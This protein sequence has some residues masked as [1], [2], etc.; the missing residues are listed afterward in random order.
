MFTRRRLLGAAGLVGIATGVSAC[1]GTSGPAEMRGA[2]SPVSLEVDQV[3]ETQRAAMVSASIA[4]GILTSHP[5]ALTRNA[6]ISPSSLTVS[7]AM[8]GEGASGASRDSLHETFDMIPD[9]RS[10]AIGALRQ[11]LVTYTDLPSGMDPD[12]PPKTPRVHQ[13]NRVVVLDDADV[14]QNFL[15]RLAT[16]YDTGVAQ[17]SRSKAEKNLDGWLKDQTAGL[18]ETSQMKISDDTRVLTQDTIV[19]AARWQNEFE[20]DDVELPFTT[21]DGTRRTVKAMQGTFTVETLIGASETEGDLFRT[22]RLPYDDGLAMDITLPTAAIDVDDLLFALETPPGGGWEDDQKQQV[23]ITMPIVDVSSA[24]ELLEPLNAQGIDLSEMDGVFEHASTGQMAQQL[25]LSVT[26]RGT[27]GAAST[28]VELTTTAP[29]GKEILDIT[30]DRPYMMCVR[31]TR[32]N[33]PLFVAVVNDP[34][35]AAV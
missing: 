10:R 35:S 32:T 4:L 11:T 34:T 21:G 7:L 13:A 28:E 33:W 31:D 8:L 18:F 2:P 6:V 24:W 5:E 23:R 15:D 22:F 17:V 9:R 12:T 25:R 16:F 20:R 19:L 27:V 3:P 30:V 1:S 29:Q 14:Q 26:A